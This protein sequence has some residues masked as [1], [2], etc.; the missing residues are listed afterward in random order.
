MAPVTSGSGKREN[1]FL[2]FIEKIAGGWQRIKKQITR[3]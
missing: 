3:F 2:I 1:V